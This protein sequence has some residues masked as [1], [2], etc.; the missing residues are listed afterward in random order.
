VIMQNSFKGYTTNFYHVFEVQEDCEAFKERRGEVE[1]QRRTHRK[2]SAPVTEKTTTR[3]KGS[4][5]RKTKKMAL[6]KRSTKT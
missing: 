5:T 6:R 3:K 2:T 4:S 1:A